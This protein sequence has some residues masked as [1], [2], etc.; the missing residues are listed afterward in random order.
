[1]EFDVDRSIAI[2][3]RTPE[4]L[5]TLL[6]D[7][8][9]D[10]THENEGPDTW[11]PFDVLGHLVHGERTDW[12]TRARI[13]QSEGENRPFDPFDRFAQFEESRGKSLE[14][15]LQEFRD[16]RQAS[17]AALMELGLDENSL[18]QRGVHPNLGRVTMRELLSTWV[19]HD[20]GHI[21]QIVRTMAKQY[22]GN[23]GPWREYLPVLSDRLPEES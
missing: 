10:W 20:L 2:L 17:L 22:A 18:D 7:L 8:P 11:S 3:A 13:L 14:Q 19:V 5:A 6:H 15:L 12:I 23:V 4:V 16:A 21:N 1:M 9:V